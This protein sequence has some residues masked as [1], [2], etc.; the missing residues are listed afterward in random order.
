MRSYSLMIL[1]STNDVHQ[2]DA[3]RLHG[4]NCLD[5]H[6]KSLQIDAVL[7]EAESWKMPRAIYYEGQGLMTLNLWS[8]KVSMPFS[9]HLPNL[10][11]WHLPWWT[12]P[13]LL[14]FLDHDIC[15]LGLLTATWCCAATMSRACLVASL[16]GGRATPG[17]QL[18]MAW[19]PR[20]SYVKQPII[21]DE[22]GSMNQDRNICRIL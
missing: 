19:T 15:Y 13:L 4:G 10:R 12:L 8:G 9:L 16:S 22:Y 6:R 2:T 17:C 20:G 5:M 7:W 21:V 14:G 11:P 3:P 1:R 18:A